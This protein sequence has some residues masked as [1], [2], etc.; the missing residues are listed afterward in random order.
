[1]CD[2][3]DGNRLEPVNFFSGRLEVNA[4]MLETILSLKKHP[5]LN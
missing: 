5:L 4:D 2:N 1:M 3:Y